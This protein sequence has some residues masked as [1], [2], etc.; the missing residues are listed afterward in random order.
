MTNQCQRV[1]VR[2]RCPTP[3][4]PFFGGVGDPRHEK[5]DH[6]LERVEA[7]RGSHRRTQV[8][9]GVDIVKDA[10]A[11]A[12]FEILDAPDVQPGRAHNSFGRVHGVSW[13]LGK[14]NELDRRRRDGLIRRRGTRT[15]AFVRIADRRGAQIEPPVGPDPQQSRRLTTAA[16]PS[17]LS[18]RGNRWA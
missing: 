1:F 12:R 16:P 2:P 6:T 17:T 4:S 9:V 5:V 13:H 7:V 10:P 18:C 14:W 15:G 3:A 8:R 11:V